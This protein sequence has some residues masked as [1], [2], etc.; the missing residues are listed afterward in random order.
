MRS[1]PATR[2]LLNTYHK[3]VELCRA[4]MYQESYDLLK[5]LKRIR[6]STPEE[7]E[8]Q[9]WKAANLAATVAYLHSRRSGKNEL[10]DVGKRY[11]E[12]AERNHPCDACRTN[13]LYYAESATD[14]F[15]YF[16]LK[17]IACAPPEPYAPMNPSVWF[18]GCVR[19]CIVRA[20]NYRRFPRSWTALEDEVRT[21]NFIVTF[22]EEWNQIGTVEMTDRAERMRSRLPWPRGYEDCRPFRLGEQNFCIATVCDT[23][24][25]GVQ[26][27]AL[28]QLDENYAVVTAEI[29][30]GPWTTKRQ[31]NWVPIVKG[32]EIFFLYAIR[33]PAPVVLKYVD[34]RIWL[35]VDRHETVSFDTPR[36]RGSSQAV[37][38]TDGW[39]FIGHEMI[40][41]DDSVYLH[42]FVLLSDQFDVAAMSSPFYFHKRGVEFCA[43]LLRDGDRLVASFGVNDCEAWL[44]FFS[45]NEVLD[46]LRLRQSLRC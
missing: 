11:A 17:P 25:A 8:I 18:D 30:R 12:I 4:G 32:N 40:D 24:D 29:L 37:R 35:Q 39:L 1:K 26:E 23:N 7:H 3:S 19:R 2:K 42:R 38:I 45:L 21:R 31:K 43:G 20:V 9:Q 41:D 36:F 6:P 13:R 27:M 28:L 15:R 34:K 10:Y 46:D 14:V 16:R 44:A 22:D 33:D 5:R